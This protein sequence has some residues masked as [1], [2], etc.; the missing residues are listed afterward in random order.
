MTVASDLRNHIVPFFGGVTLDQTT[1]EDI[2]RYVA[3]KRREL[4]VKTIRNHIGTMHSV[5]GRA[6]RGLVD[7]AFA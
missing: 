1:P 4:A 2:E 5:R 6:A 7:R 3:A